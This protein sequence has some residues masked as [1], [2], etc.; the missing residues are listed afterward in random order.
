MKLSNFQSFSLPLIPLI[1]KT[2]ASTNCQ[3]NEGYNFKYENE[4]SEQAC[5]ENRNFLLE[6]EC[7]DECSTPEECSETSI[8]QCV[9]EKKFAKLFQP[10]KAI[11]HNKKV[12]NDYNW[13]A[14]ARMIAEVVHSELGLPRK[15]VVKHLMNYGCH[16]FNGD[17]TQPFYSGGRGTPVNELDAI[18][19]SHNWCRACTKEFSN[20]SQGCS[21]PDHNVYDVEFKSGNDISCSNSFGAIND[22]GLH[23]C[24]CDRQFALD[25]KNYFVREYLDVSTGIVDYQPDLQFWKNRKNSQV[26]PVFAADYQAYCKIDGGYSGAKNACCGDLPYSRPYFTGTH[27][28]CLGKV[29]EL[30]KC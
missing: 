21:N 18:C 20:S 22:C 8:Q 11:G 2:L 10:R 5:D 19:R 3:I 23:F 9:T 15:T 17:L 24:Q 25:I 13:K 29:V 28:C 30:G 6:L 7:E 14:I 4:I 27:E 26:D 1:S 12:N 16:C